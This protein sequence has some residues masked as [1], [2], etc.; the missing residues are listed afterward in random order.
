VPRRRLNE[1][2][3]EPPATVARS[4]QGPTWNAPVNGKPPVNIVD[5]GDRLRRRVRERDGLLRRIVAALEQDERVVAAWLGGSLGRG[6]DDAL[7][8]VDLWLVVAD[9]RMATVAETRRRFVA[10]GAAPVLIEEAPENA[11]PGGAYLLALY[12]GATGPHQVDWYW[13]PRAMATLP[14]HCRLLFDRVGL[15]TTPAPHPVSD[16]ERAEAL[17]Q[18]VARFWVGALLAAK[19]IAR[20]QAWPAARMLDWTMTTLAEVTWLLTRD[21]P[22]SHDDLKEWQRVERWA[23]PGPDGRG[24]LALLREMIAALKALTPEMAA[25]GGEPAVE[26]GRQVIAFLDVVGQMIEEMER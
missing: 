17:T 19:A 2:R 16:Q 4:R 8:D 20:G 6:T 25:R 12:S 18:N 26:G 14:D 9:D 7:S 13:Q 21:L 11:P 23:F 22:P 3:S 24:Q 15:P 5:E 1:T 10:E